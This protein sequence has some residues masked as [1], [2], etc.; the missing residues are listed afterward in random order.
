MELKVHYRVYKIPS[1][2]P[3]LRKLNPVHIFLPYFS[4]I[5]SNIILPS[6]PSSSVC[7]F[8]FKFSDT[9]FVYNSYSP[10]CM[11]HAPPIVVVIFGGA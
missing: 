8:S 3:I 6:T 5:Q 4:K 10:P 11:L 7:S 1:L 9:N 2:V